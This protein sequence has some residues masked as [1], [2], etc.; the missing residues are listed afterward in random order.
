MAKLYGINGKITGKVGNTVFAIDGG[1]QVA[2]QYNPVVANPRTP[3][4]VTRR[5]IVSLAGQMSGGIPAAALEGLGGNKRQRRSTLNRN[6]MKDA[7]ENVI[8]GGKTEIAFRAERLVLSTGPKLLGVKAALTSVT[9]VDGVGDD[10]VV[11]ITPFNESDSLPAGER[12]RVV[13]VGAPSNDPTVNKGVV[14]A[15]ADVVLEPASQRVVTMRIPYNAGE[16]ERSFAAYVIPL[17]LVNEGLLSANYVN[18]MS[19]SQMFVLPLTEVT[20]GAY[21]YGRSVYLGMQSNG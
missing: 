15:V 2:R 21:E 4:Q 14:S 18:A 13:V 7:F 20:N 8:V 5:N 17:T 6:L 10:V 16:V 9:A 11:T 12:V 19:T 1:I 3:A